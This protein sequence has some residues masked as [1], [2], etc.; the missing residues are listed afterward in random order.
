MSLLHRLF[1]I[2]CCLPFAGCWFLGS[3]KQEHAFQIIEGTI[4]QCGEV[5]RTGI[6][7]SQAKFIMFP[8]YS[9]HD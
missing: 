2:V 3:T 4:G 7:G 9:A 1:I 6:I 5:N 8:P